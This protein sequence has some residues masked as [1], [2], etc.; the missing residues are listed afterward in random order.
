MY[1]DKTSRVQL[2]NALSSNSKLSPEKSVNLF[3]TALSENKPAFDIFKSKA[4]KMG[5]MGAPRPM[6]Y[7]HRDYYQRYIKPGQSPKRSVTTMLN[8]ESELSL[9]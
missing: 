2:K 7:E 5:L 3:I 9:M 1:A 4:Q 8:R 6:I